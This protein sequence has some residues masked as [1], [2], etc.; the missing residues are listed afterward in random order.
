MNVLAAIV[1]RLPGKRHPMFP[2]N[3][4]TNACT[5]RLNC[6]EP[7]RITR[8]PYQ[9]LGVRGDEFPM[10][11]QQ[12]AIGTVCEEAV[13]ERAASRSACHPLDHTDDDRHAMSRRDARQ[14]G[15]TL[16]GNVDTAIGKAGE[17]RLRRGVIPERGSR[18]VIEPA[19]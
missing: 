15:A 9:A 18:T 8:P 11:V 16:P 6:P 2:A 12:C 3:Q 19:G 7:L 10:M 13:V 14:S 5:G 1:Q 17:H 4:A